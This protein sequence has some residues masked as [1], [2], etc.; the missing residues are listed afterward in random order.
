LKR[1]PDDEA[2]LFRDSVR[3]VKRLRARETPVS[4]KKPPP[5]A[6]AAN[7]EVPAAGR[8]GEAQSTHPPGLTRTQLRE[9]RRGRLRPEDE[10]DLHGLTAARA[11][12]VLRDFLAS[13]VRRGL[14]HVRIVHGKGLRS[15]SAGPVLK[16]LVEALLRS[17]PAIQTFTPAAP[18]DGGTGAVNVLLRKG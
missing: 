17:D 4:R 10:L 8:S 3:D 7:R 6:R 1:P 9:L 18:R 15:G 5:R 2:A 11:E 14:R 13:A 16:T 12:R